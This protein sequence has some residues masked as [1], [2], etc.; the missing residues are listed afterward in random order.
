MSFHGWD[1]QVLGVLPLMSFVLRTCFTPVTAISF[2]VYSFVKFFMMD[3]QPFTTQ[4][5][6]LRMYGFTRVED[7]FQ[8]PRISM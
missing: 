2:D 1:S 3:T 7:G 5:V 6:S 4:S 8:I